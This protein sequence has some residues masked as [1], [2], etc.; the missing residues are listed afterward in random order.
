[1]RQEDTAKLWRAPADFWR[2]VDR[3]DEADNDEFAA[4][5]GTQPL[6]SIPG[7]VFAAQAPNT[8]NPP[9]GGQRIQQ[10]TKLGC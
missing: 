2:F 1:M 7:N 6:R 5:S 4:S 9:L 8:R 3:E 10:S